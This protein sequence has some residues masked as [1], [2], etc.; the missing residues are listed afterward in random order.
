MLEQLRNYGRSSIAKVLFGFLAIMFAFWGL[1]TGFFSQVRPVANVNG[2]RILA[3]Q[4]E[5]EATKLRQNVQQMYGANAPA[6]LRSINVRQAALDQLIEAQLIADEARH[7]GVSISKEA[8]QAKIAG[9]KAFQRNGQFDFDTYQEILRANNLLPTEYEAAQRT[10]MI[11]DTLEGMI[12]AG[13][14]VSDD[15]VRH[16]YNLRSEKI[17]LR[18]I[19]VPYTDFTAK[20]SP[21][22]AQLA[23]Y[24]KQNAELFREP[25]RVK[26]VFIHYQPLVLAAAYTSSDKEIEDYYKR[27]L[28]TAFTHPE[29]VHARHILIA[30]DEGA[31]EAEKKKAKDKALDV[32]KQAQSGSD[33]AKLAAKYS[34][35]PGS[36]A[37]GGDLGNFGRGQMIKPFE[38]AVFA[39]KPGQVSFVETRFGYHVIKLDGAT[40]AHTDTLA[41]ARP[42]A[43]EALRTQAGSKL[44]RDAMTEDLT[45]AMGG[46]DLH[47]VA[48]KRGLEAVETSFFAADEPIKGA[49]NDRTVVQAAFKLEPGQVHAVPEHGAPYLIKLIERQPSRIPPL[50]DIQAKVHDALIRTTA[51]ADARTQAQNM[52]EAIKD[53]SNFDKVAKDKNLSIKTVEPFTRSD[54]AVPGIGNFPEVTDA[55]GI[56]T[57]VPG[58][59]PRVMEHGGNSYIFE[60]ISRTEPS[61]D[62][63]KAAQKAFT[64][65]YVEQRRAQAWTRFLEQL[66]DQAKIRIDADQLGAG[67]SSM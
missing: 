45:T 6:M 29:Q 13:V 56:V 32:L 19:E 34:E 49:E 10:D 37:N 26:I 41:E 38:D 47:E 63:W 2:Q 8:L 39:M 9:T 25:E 42:R 43:I 52:A 44:A 5:Q 16:A 57:S 28:K 61:P 7:L 23:A 50:K 31:S 4:V 48:K 12:R 24:Y 51:E 1:G 46:T 27:N 3:N 17:G 64:Q 54:N 53:P 22:D 66:K 67:Q 11:R 15:E 18:Y 30:V 20:V 21:T 35:D 65:E 36:K 58:V 62:D 40:P 60:V 14:Q 55:A 59:I 33:F